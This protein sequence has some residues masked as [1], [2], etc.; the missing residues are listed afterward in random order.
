MKTRFALVIGT[1]FLT[2]QGTPVQAQTTAWTNLVKEAKFQ[3]LMKKKNTVVVDV[4]T[5]EEYK[6]GHIPGAIQIDIKDTAEFISKV[7]SLDKSKQY[8]LYCGTNRRSQAALD[9]M[10]LNG[11]T[12]LYHLKGGIENWEG[13]RE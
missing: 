9:I 8:L 6:G 4:R 11:F 12:R 10:K 5:I 2:F 1:L 3:R 13:K 7:N